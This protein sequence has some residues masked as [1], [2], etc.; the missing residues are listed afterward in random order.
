MDF[1]KSLLQETDKKYQEM[2]ADKTESPF[3]NNIHLASLSEY[4]QKRKKYSFRRKREVERFN[5]TLEEAK[6]AVTGKLR[7]KE[8]ILRNKKEKRKKVRRFFL[9]VF[10]IA[11]IV[12]FGY[13]VV[14][15]MW[16]QPNLDSDER[17]APEIVQRYD[18][19]TAY[20]GYA[21]LSER[22]YYIE[23]FSCDAEGNVT[24]KLVVKH[25]N[26]VKFMDISYTLQGK[27]EKIANNG[28]IKVLLDAA[29]VFNDKIFF[30]PIETVEMTLSE[31]AAE[32]KIK[33]KSISAS[34]K[35]KDFTVS[36]YV[37][38]L[39]S[40]LK[41][42][43]RNPLNGNYYQVLTEALTWE[44]AMMYCERLGGH[45][46]T[47]TDQS[48]N[49]FC[50]TLF[51][52]S[53][54]NICYL[55]GSDF[56]KDGNWEWITNENWQSHNTFFHE[57]EPSGGNQNV[58]CYW[59]DFPSGEWDDIA[60]TSKSAYMCEWEAENIAY[61]EENYGMLTSTCSAYDGALCFDG[62][63]YQ[64]F[65]GIA[66]WEDAITFCRAMGGMMPCITNEQENNALC[67]YI[68]EYGEFSPL[69]GISDQQS[70][71]VWRDTHGNLLNY[72]NWAAKEPNNTGGK[73][74]YAQFAGNDGTWNDNAWTSA[75]I[76]KW[77]DVDL[78]LN[79]YK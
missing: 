63:V 62:N 76:C 78:I 12:A 29:I 48:E 28:K 33:F 72:T 70:E 50:S 64:V 41:D 8:N 52:A 38:S 22:E 57:N 21:E 7:E 23:I 55:G 5:Q 32:G 35:D 46:A 19:K 6:A 13:F 37:T 4:D 17:Y 65:T 43:V 40:V 47:V 11:A 74:H 30:D 2:I 51:S 68:T 77:N 36:S 25:W 14:F 54:A 39:E 24:G 75:I 56:D 31:D 66:S 60:S 67:S 9:T 44:Q 73:E 79:R 3:E 15:K 1:E 53:G 20:S 61:V 16:I 34:A 45:L 10:I 26:L 27:V 71:G 59:K 49:T 42:A 58:L 18:G 69:F